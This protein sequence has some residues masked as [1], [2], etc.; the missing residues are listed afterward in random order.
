MQVGVH[1]L[2]GFL[3]F[4]DLRAQFLQFGPAD[5]QPLRL[6][7]HGLDTGIGR[8]LA[9]EL[10]IFH[11]RDLVHFFQEGESQLDRGAL[12]DRSAEVQ[13]QYRVSGYGRLLLSDADGGQKS[14]EQHHAAENAEP[15]AYDETKQE[16]FH[17]S[18]V[19]VY[20]APLI[21]CYTCTRIGLTNSTRPRNRIGWFIVFLALLPAA[22]WG[23]QARHLD[24]LGYFHDDGMYLLAAK[25]LAESGEYRIPNLPEQPA[26][27][28]YPPG[29]PL[30]LSLVWRMFP[31]FPANLP[32]MMLAVWCL[33]PVN[34]LLTMR[35]LESWGCSRFRAA[36]LTAWLTLNPYLLFLGLNLMSDLMLSALLASSLLLAQR[37]DRV[38]RAALA[39]LLG[40]AAYLTKAAALPLLAV[41]PVWLLWQ[42][43][44]RG[45]VA[46]AVPALLAG[47]GWSA[48]VAANGTPPRDAT[49]AYYLSYLADLRFQFR[50]ADVP[51]ILW[52]NV[53][54][55]LAS[56]GNLLVPDSIQIPGIGKNLSR[57]LG[58]FAIVGI[59]RQGRRLGLGLA[60]L[61]GA[62]YAVMV[63]AWVYPPNERF[64]IPLAALI[65]FGAQ[66]ELSHLIGMVQP[67]PQV[68]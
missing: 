18:L 3:E 41:A 51:G 23:W 24:H 5:A 20:R 10:P 31:A 12:G 57:L 37:A 14:E 63:I 62:A 42:R 13:H 55:F 56:A 30:L 28:K 43:R 58:I 29:L 54:T 46:F 38:K 36:F 68:P 7:H 22:Y 52:A 47:I 17:D 4:D 16:V 9:Q 26:Q 11:H 45:A 64:L 6:E 35:L 21:A 49:E 66:A 27:T 60:C 59:A 40:G 65:L 39:G 48:W 15:D 61:Y 1:G 19:S 34:A 53:H 44:R 50:L 25:T 32:W 8:R 2:A 33:L 67:R